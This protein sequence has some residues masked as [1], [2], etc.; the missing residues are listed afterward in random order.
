MLPLRNLRRLLVSVVAVLAVL[1]TT[2]LA[3]QPIHMN[4]TGTSADPNFGGCGIATTDVVKF[5]DNF[6]PIVVDANGNLLQFKDTGWFQ[7]IATAANGK[8]VTVESAGLTTA[9]ATP[10]GDG[11]F[12]AIL[13]NI[14]L[15][16]KISTTNGPTLTRDA[17]NVSRIFIGTFD[18]QH[19][20]IVSSVTIASVAGPHPELASGFT[21]F[22]QVVTAALT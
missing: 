6:T 13:N 3:D 11:T 12:T 8:S 10:N 20:F 18:A 2:A 1:P 15:P 7:V 21:L 9:V 14:G 16:E 4:F 5:A 22:C 19:N 17:G